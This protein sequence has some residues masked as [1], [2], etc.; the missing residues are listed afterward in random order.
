LYLEQ[1]FFGILK[2]WD[3]EFIFT[4]HGGTES[5]KSPLR[6]ISSNFVI[7]LLFTRGFKTKLAIHGL[8]ISKSYMVVRNC[9]QFIESAITSVANNGR[10]E[11]QNSHQK[12]EVCPYQLSANEIDNIWRIGQYLPLYS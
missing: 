12:L 10:Y 4:N 3:I 8:D 6:I 7:I 9:P 11:S 5:Q 2:L 1:A